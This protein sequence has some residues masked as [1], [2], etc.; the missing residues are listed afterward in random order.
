MQLVVALYD[1]SA[2]IKALQVQ[3]PISSL[4]PPAFRDVQG[5]PFKSPSRAYPSSP[6]PL[7]FDP[8]ARYSPFNPVRS[9]SSPYKLPTFEN[10]YKSPTKAYGSLRSNADVPTHNELHLNNVES[11]LD[12]RTTVMLKVSQFRFTL[13]IRLMCVLA[14]HCQSH[15]PKRL[16]SHLGLCR[17]RTV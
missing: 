8:D 3:S 5:D 1:W 15:D 10:P 7:R 4:S 9:N 11:G 12:G 14:E 2:P 16:T 17:A 6:S 13:Y